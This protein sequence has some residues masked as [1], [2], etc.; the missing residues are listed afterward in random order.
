VSTSN[1]LQES[2]FLSSHV[3]RS[4]DFFYWPQMAPHQLIWCCIHILMRRLTVSVRRLTR[5]YTSGSTSPPLSLNLE[6]C[7]CPL[8]LDPVEHQMMIDTQGKV[9]LARFDVVPLRV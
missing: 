1:F 2:L 7:R 8:P 5:G 4:S 6:L 9:S 3:V